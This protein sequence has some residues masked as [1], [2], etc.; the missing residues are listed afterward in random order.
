MR[1]LEFLANLSPPTADLPAA[2]F[3]LHVGFKRIT[4]R[5]PQGRTISIDYVTCPLNIFQP[6][7]AYSAYNKSREG[8]VAVHGYHALG[9]GRDA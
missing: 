5:E 4:C 6:P 3:F 8:T 9:F 2:G 7:K 1:V